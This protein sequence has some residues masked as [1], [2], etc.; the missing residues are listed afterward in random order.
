MPD[1]Q[2][3]VPA[4]ACRETVVLVHG[5]WMLGVEMKLLARRLRQA[6]YTVRQFRYPSVRGH[7]EPNVE[8]LRRY[9]EESEGDR[10]HF[11]AHSLGG[12]LTH[13]LFSRYPQQRPGQIVA[14]GTPFNGSWTAQRIERLGLR[15]PILGNTLLPLL[16]RGKPRWNGESPLAVIAGTYPLGVGQ[17]LGRMPGP[18]DGTVT[19]EETFLEGATLHTSAPV[20]HFGLLV[21]RP[22]FNRIVGFLRAGT[23][24]TIEG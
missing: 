1:T 24:S 12:L 2:P 14:L 7:V 13:E 4:Q 5:I 16:A 11:V 22:V 17:V 18:N 23:P 9:V 8:A 10:V 20:N 6:G 19:L 15:R 3:S 21:S